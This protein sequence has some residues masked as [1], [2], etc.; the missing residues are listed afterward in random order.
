M[1]PF[2]L[3]L[4]E[5]YV[6][7]EVARVPAAPAFFRAVLLDLQPRRA[8]KHQAISL[9]VASGLRSIDEARAAAHVLSAM[10]RTRIQFDF[11]DAMEALA[12]LQLAFPELSSPLAIKMDGGR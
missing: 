12:H 9:L 8:V 4:A 2:T 7:G 6:T 11:E 1:R 5:A 10:L 3:T